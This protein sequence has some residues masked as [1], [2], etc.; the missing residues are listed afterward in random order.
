MVEDKNQA[1][2]FIKENFCPESIV[3]SMISRLKEAFDDSFNDV[4]ISGNKI[5]RNTLAI[6]E[7]IR[8]LSECLFLMRK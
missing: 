3:E 8:N 1:E 5:G 2:G 4:T 7:E 6:S